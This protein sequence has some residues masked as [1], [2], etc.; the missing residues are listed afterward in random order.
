M[1]VGGEPK[2]LKRTLKSNNMTPLSQPHDSQFKC[3][4]YLVKFTHSKVEENDNYSSQDKL[5]CGS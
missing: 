3:K 1:G 5:L 4:S 2:M